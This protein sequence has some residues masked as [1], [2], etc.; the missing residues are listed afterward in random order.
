MLFLF[1]F[2]IAWT[3]EATALFHLFVINFNLQTLNYYYINITCVLLL[4]NLLMVFLFARVLGISCTACIP[5]WFSILGNILT[6]PRDNNFLWFDIGCSF[7]LSI[8][9][10]KWAVSFMQ[11][12]ITSVKGE[13]IIAIHW[14]KFSIAVLYP[15]VNNWAGIPALCILYKVALLPD[16]AWLLTI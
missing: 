15:D 7:K 1:F 16:L 3:I 8:I 13:Q 10:S 12:C 11:H 4:S 2:F 14:D 9:S 5:L 6:I